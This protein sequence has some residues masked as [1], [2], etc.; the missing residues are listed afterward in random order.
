MTFL[1]VLLF[2]LAAALATAASAQQTVAIGNGTEP[3]TLDPHKATDVSSAEIIFQLFEG[4]VSYGP[5]AA[6]VPGVA[7]R[8]ERSADGLSYVFHLRDNARWS[9]GTPVTAEDFVYSLRRA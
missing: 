5:D 2:L 6:I 7:E 3:E 8:W 1:R 9:D 4:L